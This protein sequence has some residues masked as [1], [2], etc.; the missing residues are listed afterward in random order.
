MADL[1]EFVQ[2]LLKPVAY[3]HPVSHV[4][5]VQTHIS[6]VF[7]TDSFVYKVKKQVDF[8]FVNFSTLEKRRY[9]CSQEVELN[10]RL[11]PDV[12]LGV[13]EIRENNGTFSI[14]GAGTTVEYAVK[15]R[16]LPRDRIMSAML[17]RNEVTQNHVE[18]IAS[19]LAKFHVK[20]ATSPEISA[21]GKLDGLGVGRNVLEN[22]EQTEKYIGKTISRA[23]WRRVKEY[24]Q[25]FMDN[26]RNLFEHRVNSGKIR[27]CH[28]DTHSAQI[29]LADKVY[30]LDCIEFND[31]FRYGDVINDVAFLAMDL[32]YSGRPDLSAAFVSKY[33]RD[34]V[35]LEGL[36]L[37]D[38]YK[39]YLGFVRA[40]VS[41]FQLDDPHLGDKERAAAAKNAEDYF[42]LAEHYAYRSKRPL[43]I[44][45]SGLSGSG[46]S[47][48]ARRLGATFNAKVILSDIL[49]KTLAGVP[50]TEH[51]T[52]QFGG[53]IYT[54]EMTKRTYDEMYRQAKEEISTGRSVVLD[55]AFLRRD[56]RLQARKSAD[57]VN[58]EFYMIECV[59]SDDEV[60]RRLDR[61]VRSGSS[62]SDA[63]FDTYQMQ[64]KNA[65][66]VIE[67]PRFRHILAD[68]TVSTQSALEKIEARLKEFI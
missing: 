29:F 34:S 66:P 21:F 39:C 3:P 28:G 24:A 13:E 37:L 54:P 56:E 1:P 9:F 19:I 58:A 18:D 51:R 68:T 25:G 41:N 11:S 14:G 67:M 60:R 43:M 36:R 38:F 50:L 52:E 64:K 4:E 33:E 10:K 17:A 35:D 48:V 40:K 63:T 6:Y 8:G 62:P 32:D 20:A 23:R 65:E 45:M 55:A 42:D 59:C 2:G 31:R 53:G 49:R 47:S 5:L 61:R 46:K 16:L 44:V 12:Y 27:D 7:I 30:I 57:D 15:M 26:N 22:F